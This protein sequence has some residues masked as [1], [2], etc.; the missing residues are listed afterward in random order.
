MWAPSCAY[1]AAM[2]DVLKIQLPEFVK[3]QAWEDCAREGGYRYVHPK[4]CLVVD[5][6]EVLCVDA[7]HRPHCET[8]PS[9]RWRDGWS[10]WYWHGVRVTEQIVMRP[11][12]I[13]VEQIRAER[14]EEVRRVMIERMGAD[15][16]VREARLTL[17]DE[18]PADHPI[19]GLRT[20]RLW[21]DAANGVYIAD[22]LNST[23]EPDGSVKRYHLMVDGDAYDGAARQSLHAAVAS[24]WR[25]GTDMRLAFADWRDYRPGCET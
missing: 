14:N 7:A 23:P 13:T 15:R 11:D 12:T 5:R 8:G 9:H 3:Y 18:A 21:A 24:T 2:R 22:V 4:F 19:I 1:L 10:L 16:Y 17:I 6:P 25:V 20:G